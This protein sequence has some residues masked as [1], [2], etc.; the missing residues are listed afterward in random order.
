MLFRTAEFCRFHEG[1]YFFVAMWMMW[2]QGKHDLEKKVHKNQVCYYFT[3][4]DDQILCL[5]FEK[6]TSNLVVDLLVRYLGKDFV[7]SDQKNGAT[8]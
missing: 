4:V 8:K 1:V 7:E 5:N 3:K 6:L 2:G